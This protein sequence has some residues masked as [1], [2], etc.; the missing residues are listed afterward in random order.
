MGMKIFKLYFLRSD[1]PF[2][3]SYQKGKKY[4]TEWLCKPYKKCEGHK[5]Y[6]IKLFGIITVYKLKR[7]IM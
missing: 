1:T 4:H 3:Q 2:K 6:M 5:V 7:G